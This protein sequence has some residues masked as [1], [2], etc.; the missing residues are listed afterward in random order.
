MTGIIICSVVASLIIGTI[1]GFALGAFSSRVTAENEANVK[2]NALHNIMQTLI[3]SHANTTTVL[4]SAMNVHERIIK[5]LRKEKLQLAAQLEEA[6]DNMMEMETMMESGQESESESDSEDDEGGNT[7]I[8]AMPQTR[9]REHKK[10]MLSDDS[11][12]LI[13]LEKILVDAE[14]KGHV[15][16]P[17]TLLGIINHKLD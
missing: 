13:T 17:G 12:K 2:V 16:H 15:V 8:V 3:A 10:P 11:D 5:I 9:T 7:K 14:G 4:S 1:I 6:T